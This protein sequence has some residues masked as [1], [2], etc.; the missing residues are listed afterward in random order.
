MFQA[1]KKRPKA[2]GEMRQR[3]TKLLVIV[4][5]CAGYFSSLPFAVLLAIAIIFRSFRH[6]LCEY[7]NY[8]MAG[9]TVS[10]GGKRVMRRG[11]TKRNSTKVT[12]D[13]SEIQTQT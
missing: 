8:L 3:V 12:W 5:C 9:E 1:F 13:T 10:G 6:V 11:L 7:T 4:E 2:W